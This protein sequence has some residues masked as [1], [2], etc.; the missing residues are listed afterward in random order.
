MTGEGSS[1]TSEIRLTVSFCPM[2][3]PARFIQSSASLLRTPPL[4]LVRSAISNGI[5]NPSSV[6]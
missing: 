5:C 1:A 3:A 4:C 2:A 6:F